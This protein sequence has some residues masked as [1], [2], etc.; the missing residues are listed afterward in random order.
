MNKNFSFG[1]AFAAGWQKLKDNALF[2]VGAYLLI[3]FSSGVFSYLSEAQYKDIEPTGSIFALVGLF[4]R[5]WLNFNLLVITIRLFDGEVPKWS[6]LFVWRRETLSYVGASILYGVI[7]M[8]GLIAFVIPGLYFMIKY[9]FYGFLIADKKV[10]AF[11]ALKQSGQLTDGVKWLLIGFTLAS[12]GV[13]FL[14]ILAFGIGIFIAAPVVSLALIFVY[15]SLYDQTFNLA[16]ATP[17]AVVATPAVEMKVTEAVVTPASATE[18]PAE[19]TEAPKSD[20]PP[21]PPATP[22]A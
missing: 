5:V 11:D 4:L 12:I 18:K 10:G 8:L 2:L 20:T 19:T 22:A 6:D 9:S 13:I 16:S 17:A 7:I 21:T 15:R 1:E 3:L 14:G